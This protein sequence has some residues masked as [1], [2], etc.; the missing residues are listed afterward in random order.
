MARR[1]R[2]KKREV[3][4][5]QL[6]R[7][8]VVQR[9]LFKPEGT[10]L[11]KKKVPAYVRFCKRIYKMMPSL[12]G[13][14][15]Y[16]EKMR[17]A[18]EFLNWDLSAK[19]LSAAVNFVLIISLA[20]VFL[21]WFL[22]IT[23]P[24]GEIFTGMPYVHY[25][26]LMMLIIVALMLTRY[27]YMYPFAVVELEQKRALS[28]IPEIVG[29]MIMSMKL[30][31]N[32]EKS[33]EFAAEHGRG[34]IA[35]DFK[36]LLWE[37]EV[38]VYASISEGL[39][40][41]AYRWGKY[42]P[43]F[44]RALMRIRASVLEDT[45]TKRDAVLN[46][47]IEELLGS[48]KDRMEKY[49]RGLTQPS[50]VL[51]YVGILLPLILMIILPVGSIFTGMPLATPIGLI[52][53]YNI[54]IP[55]GAFHFARS[56]VKHRPPTYEAPEI[57][58]DYPGLP[59]KG[60][61]K[62]RTGTM[63]LKV[64]II[65]IA[66]LGIA[67]SYYLHI[68]G[69]PPKSFLIASGQS[70][71]LQIIKPDQTEH[72]IIKRAGLPENYFSIPDG[73][74]YRQFLLY[75]KKTAEP[76]EAAEKAKVATIFE[77][78]KFFMTKENDITPYNLWFGI[79]LTFSLCLYILLY[80]SSIYK[81]R[82]QKEIMRME[83]E[84]K[85]ALYILAS[86]LGENKPMEEALRHAKE[87]LP[88]SLISQR[89]FSR[90]LD[91]INLLGMPLDAAV[92]DSRFGSVTQIPSNTI[93]I[94]MRL[95]VDAVRLGT[96]IAART[97]VSLALQ[98]DNSE[99]VSKLLKTLIS[100]LTSMMRTMAVI[101]APIILGITTA[102]FRIVVLTIT[103]ITSS[104]VLSTE[105][106]RLPAGGVGNVPGI[107]GTG[108]TQITE[109]IG[110]VNIGSFIKPEALASIA[111]PMQFIIIIGIYVAEI[112]LTILYFATMLEEDN[113]L[114]LKVQIAKYLPLA[115][116]IYIVS[117]MVASL[118]TGSLM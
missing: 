84:F 13:R 38:G 2:A 95:V 36:R 26:L 114:V 23:S 24:L 49:A 8:I 12:G 97:L 83:S 89:I 56:I 79:I 11:F 68:E 41:I 100:D 5:G 77:K 18:I 70:E 106:P 116:V 31:P 65:L 42:S 94:G 15:E 102:L 72:E 111:E 108:L 58:D 90:T 103:K 60:K 107:G 91:N 101:I 10:Q 37:T 22:L 61:I 55:L 7:E 99:K 69:F 43:E 64:V 19:E 98:L 46:K 112:V 4:P 30:T 110:R 63:D 75:Y 115:L 81:R 29:Y 44:K 117:V 66:I 9:E 62:T 34:K 45:E 33:V 76:E 51:F 93:K 82:I 105:I 27:V 25:L 28:Y 47:T 21:A 85:D 40:R 17:A 67:A 88:N 71:D 96:N 104:G 113:K 109:S 54:A 52:A 1:K 16:S 57:P 20:S 6:Y 39:D 80:Y 35:E 86:R 48:I 87:F 118:L 59:P 53:I 74:L 78:K 73:P 14:A 32:L 50:I 92:F 3:T